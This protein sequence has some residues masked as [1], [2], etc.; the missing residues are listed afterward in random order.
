[1]SYVDESIKTKEEDAVKYFELTS[2]LGW[3]LQHNED[4]A[5]A[6][7]HLLE[8]NKAL[9]VDYERIS[10]VYQKSDPK[11]AIKAMKR[12]YQEYTLSYLFYSY[13]NSSIN[14]KNYDELNE[15]M[16]SIGNSSPLQKEALFWIIKSK[17]YAH[18]EQRELEKEALLNALTLTPNN[19]QIKL[20]LLW[21]F[22]DIHDNKNLKELLTDMTEY[23]EL[24]SSF[25]L[26][27]ASAY[28]YLNDV[29]RASYYTQE[30]L[31]NNDPITDLIQFKFLQAYIYQVQNNE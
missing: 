21:Y 31:Y 1:M 7:K 18:Y 8:M 15:M 11:L 5:L 27:L 17:I 20:T 13:A 23:N 9:L 30:L 10:F 25:Y 4:A 6:S 29:N 28:F 14:N 22:M 3:Y 2:D 26:P 19:Y 24:E 16:Q 12:A